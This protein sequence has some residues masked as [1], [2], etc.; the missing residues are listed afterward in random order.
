MRLAWWT[1]QLVLDTVGW[2][3]RP[4]KIIPDM[5]YNVFGGTL[6]PTLPVC[7]PTSTLCVHCTCVRLNVIQTWRVVS[8]DAT[9][10]FT[11]QVTEE[12]TSHNINHPQTLH[13]FLTLPFHNC[14]QGTVPSDIIILHQKYTVNLKMAK[15]ASKQAIQYMTTWCGKQH[16]K[17][18]WDFQ[19]MA[20]S[21]TQFQTWLHKYNPPKLGWKN[22]ERIP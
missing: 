20:M 12:Y 8:H 15:T 2:V 21:G 10:S 18:T 5:T 11:T 3:I 14:A 6:N 4:V 7:L 19:H 22:M 13:H 1:G 17:L 16:S 9:T